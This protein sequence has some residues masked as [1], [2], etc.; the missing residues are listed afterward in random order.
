[1]K[2][3]HKGNDITEIV[4]SI[5]WSGDYA[6]ASRILDFNM[7]VSP[8]DY[9]LPK[10]TLVMGDVIKL[11]DDDDKEV[12]RGYVFSK[13]KSIGSSEMQV[14]CYDGLVY[15]LKSKGTYNFKDMT[16]QAIT[17]KICSD[18]GIEVG[19]LESGSKLSRIFDR[20]EIY[21]IIMTAYTIESNK[22]EKLYMPKMIDGKLNVILKGNKKAKYELDARTTIIN[23]SYGESMDN[24]INR[25][26]IYDEEGKEK[27]QVKLEGVPG[28]LQEI[29]KEEEGIDANVGAK[30]LLKGIEQTASL[31]ALGNFEC[32]TGNAVVIKESFT[33]LNGLFYIDNDS[34]TFA[35]GQHSMSLGLSFKNV[36]DSQEGGDD[37]VE[38][39]KREAESKSSGSSEQSNVKGNAGE[40]IR[41]AESMIGY[42]YSQGNR[43]GTSSADCSSLVSRAMIKAGLTDNKTLTTRSIQSDG[44]FTKI[45]KG[46]LKPGDI[47][48]ETGH[49]ALFVGDGKLVEA[50]SSRGK[51]RY[52]NLGNRFTHGYRVKG[53]D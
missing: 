27:G 24:S 30:A 47:V 33:G 10:V 46:D 39:A 48:W 52:S 4:S 23:S 9:Y 21:N 50:S 37:P 53:I 45:S 3:T 36:M 11:L 32:V 2:I 28:I 19:K 31:E 34:H 20:E 25:V 29:Y 16:P 1:M 13:E 18:F 15:L 40:L 35:N 6:Q 38:I 42:N 8:T 17:G 14:T 7:A 44:R 41:A 43:F 12:F 26:K 49:M 5:E 22:T 51:V